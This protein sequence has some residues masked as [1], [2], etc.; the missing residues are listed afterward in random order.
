MAYAQKGKQ[1]DASLQLSFQDSIRVLLNNT[2]SMEVMAIGDGFSSVWA[3]LGPGQQAQ[4]KKQCRL[5]KKKGYK[6]RPHFVNYYGAIVAALAIEKIDLTGL[7][8]FLEITDKVI[9]KENSNQANIIFQQSRDFFEHHAL[10][11][12]KYFRL[13]ASDVRYSFQYLEPKVIIPDTTQSYVPPAEPDTT[14]Y[15]LPNWQQPIV[16]PEIFGIMTFGSRY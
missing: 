6:L 8:K 4:I 11:F 5:M 10:T 13:I 7:S 1:E 12:Q 15:S 14:V 3:G 9:A 16:Q 2:K